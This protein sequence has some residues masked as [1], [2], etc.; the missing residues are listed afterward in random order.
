M[1]TRTSEEIL[2]TKFQIKLVS[3]KAIFIW[4]STPLTPTKS[5]IDL[6]TNINSNELLLLANELN[7][8]TINGRIYVQNLEQYNRLLVYACVRPSLKKAEYI[9]KLRELVLEMTSWDS[10]YWASAFRELWW[11]HGKRRKLQH[12]VKAFKLFFEIGE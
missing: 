3:N 12:L 5:S 9:L 1:I 6:E 8:P 10:H 2:Q 4:S 11:K 7:N